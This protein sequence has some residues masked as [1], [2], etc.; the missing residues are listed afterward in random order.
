MTDYRYCISLFHVK[1]AVGYNLARFLPVR[2]SASR[3]ER[4]PV[5]TGRRRL[6]GYV[7][8]W[9][10]THRFSYGALLPGAGIIRV[11]GYRH[12]G[13]GSKGAPVMPAAASGFP[14]ERYSPYRLDALLAVDDR[15][16]PLPLVS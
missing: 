4:D 14:P 8:A 10:G 12:L 16:R 2:V 13:S 1:P 11:G 7:P 3:Q 5:P 6:S 15:G 9:P